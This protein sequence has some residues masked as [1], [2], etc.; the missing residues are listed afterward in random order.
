MS[1][2]EYFVQYNGGKGG[3]DGMFNVVIVS[4]LLIV[5]IVGDVEVV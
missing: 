2:L 4:V 1:V 5:L 3:C